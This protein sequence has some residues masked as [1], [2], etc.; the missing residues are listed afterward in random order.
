MKSRDD[1]Y[2]GVAIYVKGSVGYNIINISSSQMV[3]IVGIEIIQLNLVLVSVY[4]NPGITIN[5]CKT[6]IQNLLLSLHGYSQ[7]I[8]GGDF[9]S[10]HVGWGCAESNR[11]GE[12]LYSIINSSQFTLLND[13]SLTHVPRDINKRPSA[14]DLSLCTFN[15][16]GKISWKVEDFSF[17]RNA[18]K[19]IKMFLKSNM[20]LKETS[21]KIKCK[22]IINEQIK[23]IKSNS[24][25]DIQ[26][27]QN[28]LKRI[29]KKNT[30]T[31]KYHPKNYWSD[32]LSDLYKAKRNALKKFNRVSNAANLID[33]NKAEAKFT[34]QKCIEKKNNI[35]QLV[36][37]ISPQTSSKE[38]WQI[39][40]NIR[41]LR[42]NRNVTNKITGDASMAENFMKLNYTNAPRTETNN[43]PT[44]TIGRISVLNLELW[45]KILAEKSATSA[46]G[47]DEISYNMLSSLQTEVVL[48]V[49]R[50]LNLIYNRCTVPESLKTIKIIAVPKPGRNHFTEDGY[51]PIS[52]EQTLFKVLNAGVHKMMVEY[53]N[54]EDLI[55]NNS[56]GF[57][58]NYSTTSCIGYVTNIFMNKKM[59]GRKIGA[60]FFDLT[61]AFNDV[62][63]S[64]LINIM[65]KMKFPHHIVK[66]FGTA[67]VNRRT[68]MEVQN[69]IIEFNVNTGLPQGDINSPTLFNLF[70]TDFHTLNALDNTT[71]VQFAD[72]FIGI[73]DAISFDDLEIKLN[74][75][76]KKFF[77]ITQNLKLRINTVKTK[78]IIFNISKKAFNIQL[79]NEKLQQV[80]SHKYLGITLDRN[81]NFGIHI[82]EL[83]KK[84]GDRLNMLKVI[85]GTKSGSHPETLLII[86][87]ALI[88]NLMMYGASIYGTTSKTYI[89]L[90][91]ITHR[92]ALRI[93]T[94]CTKTTPVN[95]LAAIASTEP[96]VIKR[97]MQTRKEIAQYVAN[98][99]PILHQMK[100]AIK[101]TDWKTNKFV[102]YLQ[103]MYWKYEVEFNNILS[104]SDKV[105]DN[106]DVKIAPKLI[107]ESIN[108]KNN[109]TAELKQTTLATINLYEGFTKIYTDA[110]KNDAGCGIGIFDSFSN[111][112]I[113]CKL[114]NNVTIMSAELTAIYIACEYIKHYQIRKAVICTDSLSSCFY[115]LN[116]IEGG[117]F[118]EVTRKI[119][120]GS[121]G[122]IWIQWV[123][124]H[125]GLSGNE[126]ADKLAKESLLE[127]HTYINKIFFMD[128]VIGL[129]N[130]KLQY[131]DEWYQQQS[132]I[133]GHKF[134]Q[135]QNRITKYPWFHKKR[136]KG[137]NVK[138]LN[139]ILSGHDYSGFWLG[140][141]KM[142]DSCL[143]DVCGVDNTSS[144]IILECVK[145][146]HIR[147]R[148]K[149]HHH[150]SLLSLIGNFNINTM[151]EVIQYLSDINIKI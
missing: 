93:A 65:N 117:R 3:E 143:C 69:Q 95:T 82:R 34:R 132:T 2:G 128:A 137:R 122:E 74:L 86:Y 56:F 10:H 94:G 119:C 49:I 142:E 45:K 18:H 36:E 42:N 68:I 81:L 51:R 151:N 150:N 134:Y 54:K 89:E 97:E 66:W 120:Y 116:Q 64:M 135:F 14:I 6:E 20:A 136:I 63:I 26:D 111:R 72:D 29:V 71:V 106:P 75:L 4:V 57:R 24:F 9:N 126:M 113:S 77:D 60:V 144:H 17:G 58:K 102:T 84:V 146:T 121:Y 46:P 103:F 11:R 12:E 22:N 108:K 39:I 44:G 62:D 73:V 23:M 148:Y 85:N 129:K 107:D 7:V 83:K 100:L 25:F 50:E 105:F 147:V 140:K 88:T 1:G 79:N 112:K 55:S 123:P 16:V 124:G 139:R 76:C 13:G 38:A 110:S 78:F 109:T 98:D 8:I 96:L 28:D 30:R 32:E 92:K 145:F 53:I 31:I 125:I 80:N 130:K 61:N 15:L 115:L 47:E 114:K 33:L 149:F 43:S 21:Q 133:K 99:S 104:N 131:F 27:L 67:L 138:M 35:I 59:K 87:Q 5:E 127:D 52:L 118:N 141:L 19:L 41:G 48:K 40:R 90:L 37:T 70:T 101:P 91:E